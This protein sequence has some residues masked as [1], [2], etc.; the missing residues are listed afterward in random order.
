MCFQDELEGD[1]WGDLVTAL[2][3]KKRSEELATQGKTIN[4]YDRTLLLGGCV[5]GMIV[6]FDWQNDGTPGKVSFQI[7]V[8]L[9]A[10]VF[11]TLHIVS[12]DGGGKIGFRFLYIMPSVYLHHV[13]ALYVT[14][15]TKRF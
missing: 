9:L 2:K 13:C 11:S 12:C 6:L 10:K 8:S 15:A 7:E 14:K 4:A 3:S 5:N 1:S